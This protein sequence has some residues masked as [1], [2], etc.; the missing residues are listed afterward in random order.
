MYQLKTGLEREFLHEAEST[1]RLIEALPSS[2]LS[3]A[4]QPHLW[5]LGQ[6]AFHVINIYTWYDPV[7]NHSYLDVATA[8]PRTSKNYT[9]EE[10]KQTL[11]QNI[12][13]AHKALQEWN[14]ETYLDPWELRN[15]EEVLM[16]AAPKIGYI[17][18]VLFSHLYHH[19]G[20]IIAHLRTLGEKVPGL[21]GPTYE[22]MPK[23]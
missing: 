14:E 4:P 6:L 3:Y 18:G 2:A 1:R 23:P 12:S 11:E 8:P 13:S 9:I 10:L 21:Y 17:R 19:R 20:E 7:L 15:G 22:Q 5:N 16:P